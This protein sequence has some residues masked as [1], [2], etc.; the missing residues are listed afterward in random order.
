VTSEVNTSL[1]YE[2]F[3][4]ALLAPLRGHD[5][6]DDESLIASLLLDASSE[7]PIGIK[8]IVE[9]MNS[10][11][12]ENR[13]RRVDDRAVKDII[14]GLRKNHE[15][16]ILSRKFARPTKPAGYWWCQSEPEMD[17][18]IKDFS[19]QPM[20]ELHTLSRIVKANYPKLAGQLTLQDA[21]LTTEATRND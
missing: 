21:A 18:F 7:R 8:H 19:K 9:V 2:L 3:E 17:D 16:P 13:R 12:K 20:D 4:A 1:K 5:L 11:P 10:R 15:F 6:S 14:R